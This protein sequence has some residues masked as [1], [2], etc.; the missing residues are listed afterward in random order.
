VREFVLQ[1]LADRPGFATTEARDGE[2]GLEKALADPPDLILLDLQLPR[3]DGFQVLDGLHANRSEVPVILMTSHG[4]EAVAVEVFRKGVRDY[5]IKP[6]TADEMHT[7]IER[8]LAEV[9]LRR[10]KE[11]LTRHLA[12]TNQELQR[13][14]QE[15][16]TL[17]RVGK[18]VTALLARDKLLERILDAAFHI[19]G[20]ED[21]TLLLTENGSG[22][23]Q[24]KLHRQRVP[25]EIQHSGQR[26]VEELAAE[27]I[28]KGDATTTGAML[29]VPLKVGRRVIGVLGASNRVSSRPFSKHD[30]Q[31][32]LSLA[33]Y[34]AIAIEN[35]HLYESVR[36]ANDAKSEF[37]SCVAHELRTPMTA[38]KGY[39]GVLEKQAVAALSQ[40]QMEFL[41]TIRANV[42]R[43][44]G[45]VA[46]LQDVSRMETGN[47]RLEVREV[48][49]KE[50]LENA[51]QAT[52]TQIEARVQQLTLDVPENLPLLRADPARLTQILTNLISNAYKY[53]P[54][55]GRIRVR[56]WPQNGYVYCAVSDTGVGIS[57]EDQARLFEKFFRS[58]DPSVRQMPGTG[59]GL[60]IVKRLVEI[61]GGQIGVESQVGKGTT[62]TFTA[63]TS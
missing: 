43:M 61:Q 53:T 56:A 49:F 33:D 42:E 59:L 2:A 26:S 14:V 54:E 6:F 17:Y 29:Y 39:T 4:S 5:L 31:L 23:L 40:Q 22:E 10:E 48:P 30:R 20:A 11:A 38:I 15:L 1:A 9:R 24:V 47:M 58:E 16:D 7:S 21:A 41:R 35:A 13:R 8:A 46:D 3:L 27:A 55:G 44:E 12:A 36:Q 37:V 19:I 18:S 60:C 51:L 28:R 34:A 50:A 57:P 52:R 25:G 45:L 32:L 62:F 63:P